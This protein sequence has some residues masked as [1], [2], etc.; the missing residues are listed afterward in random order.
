MSKENKMPEAEE[1]KFKHPAYVTMPIVFYPNGQANEVPVPGMIVHV[2]Y[3]NQSFVDIQTFPMG[4]TGCVPRKSVR[5]VD[6]SHYKE[7]P[8][9]RKDYG[10]WDYVPIDPRLKEQVEDIIL[11]LMADDEEVEAD[12]N[13]SPGKMHCEKK[14]HLAGEFGDK[15]G[16]MIKIPGKATG[17]TEEP[18]PSK[19]HPNK[20]KQ[21]KSK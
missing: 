18:Y 17:K 5:H 4:R 11:R 12:V 2:P 10:A 13:E 14:P 15:S 21:P 9:R 19:L 6:D 3:K 7:F 20:S 16:K 1:P 8:D